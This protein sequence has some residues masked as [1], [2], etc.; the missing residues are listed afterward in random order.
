MTDIDNFASQLLEEAK[1]FLEKAVD[2]DDEGAEHAFLHA[3]LMLS[4]CALEAHIHAI[5]DDFAD[6]DVFSVHERGILQERAVRLVNG[7][8]VI[9]MDQLKVSRL[10]DRIQL[11]YRKFSGASLDRT[12]NWWSRL[13]EA[14]EVRNQLTHP[15]GV[16]LIDADI[17][18]R[19]IDA[20]VAALDAVYRAVYKRKF[21]AAGRGLTSRMHF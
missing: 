18:K 8:F 17:V 2:S 6:N 16:P 3:S 10:E 5:G 19:A 13:R 4:F 12:V 14:M 9:H 21:P 15:K 7:K 1:R 20:I 11:L